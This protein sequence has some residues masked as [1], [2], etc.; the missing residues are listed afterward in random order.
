[1]LDWKKASL[2]SLGLLSLAASLPLGARDRSAPRIDMAKARSKAA[3]LVARMSPEEK[4]RLTWGI[5][6]FSL[7]PNAPPLPVGVLPAAG[8][9]TGIPRLGIP[10]L[11]E[12]DGPLG[13]GYV[14]G[15]R[16]DY[17]T[18]M[19]CAIALGATFNR[20]LSFAYGKAIGTEARAK[21]FN[22]LLA[23]GANLAR[24]PRN[25]RT[26]EYLSEDPLLTGQMVGWNIAGIQSNR[27]VS[28]IKHFALNGQETGRKFVDV[29]I[30]DKAARESDLLAFQIGIEIGQ[31]GSVMCAYN[32]VN[33]EPGCASQYLLNEV[34]KRDWRYPGWV[35]SDWGAVPGLDAARYGLDQQSGAGLDKEVYFEKTLLQAALSDPAKM[36]RLDEMN[37]RILTGLIATGVL[38][39]PVAPGGQIDFAKHNDVAL[40]SAEEGIVL[41]RNQA[42]ILPLA[43]DAKSILVVGGYADSGVLSGGGS[44]QVHN[45]GGPAITRVLMSQGAFA[46]FTTEQYH[47]G[48]PLAAIRSRK[49]T[50]SVR[51][52]PG[53]YASDAARLA[54][55]SD[56]VIIFATQWM[57]EAVDVSDLGLPDGQDALI[58][59]IAAANP[60]T[61]VVLETGGPVNMPWL[62][63]VAGVIEAWY[64]GQA[65]AEAIAR[66]LFG[67]TNPSGRLPVSFP[68]STADLPRT[69][70][71]GMIEFDP[72]LFGQQPDPGAKLY[73]DYNIEGSDIGYRWHARTG[74]AALF[75]FGFGLSYSTFEATGLATDGR[76]ASFLLRNTGSRK[77]STVG[78]LYLVKRNGVAMRRLVGFAKVELQQGEERQVKLKIDPRLLADW[79]GHGWSIASGTYEFALGDDAERIG[80]IKSVKLSSR[81]WRD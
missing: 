19:P 62:N 63:D 65:G 69:E 35:M 14:M 8:F 31:P 39:D 22:V 79:N 27:V 45:K 78:Q 46:S 74:R 57:A 18:A 28:T 48:A 53:R 21:G 80:A 13:I 2:V 76:T 30:S 51:F 40:Q 23:G 38:G 43:R 37:V 25:G 71:P 73:T 5:M 1:M 3:A 47:R 58:S 26:F 68:A 20:Q 64:P 9:V 32:K 11:T 42:G 16:G 55:K 59:Q 56:L 12:T 44:S 77:G 10:D 24:D 61:I 17:A 54:A 50:G 75:P 33:G 7:A 15:L 60:N 34:L 6:P 81:N 49:P 70:V 4:V 67:E 29:Q 52:R 41:L 66:V 72:V 36:A